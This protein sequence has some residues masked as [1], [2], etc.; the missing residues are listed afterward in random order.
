MTGSAFWTATLERAARTF[1]QA[2][3][4]VLGAAGA[5]LLDAPWL[6]ALSAAAMAAV[7]SLLTSIATPGGPGVTERPTGR[8]RHRPSIQGDEGGGE[9]R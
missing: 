3:L 9:G 2:L 1:A 6:S 7:L 8:H 4:A 5:G